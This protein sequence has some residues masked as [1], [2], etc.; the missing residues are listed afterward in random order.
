MINDK[1]SQDYYQ[2]Q[3]PVAMFSMAQFDVFDWAGKKYLDRS[4]KNLDRIGENLKNNPRYASDPRY[5]AKA[6]RLYDIHMRQAKDP[7]LLGKMVVG[8]GGSAALGAAAIGVGIGGSM[9]MRRRR[10]KKGKIVVEQ[11]RR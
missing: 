11:V 9:F 8:I 4:S 5:V 2:Y 10:T 7:R 1:I 3:P 6:N